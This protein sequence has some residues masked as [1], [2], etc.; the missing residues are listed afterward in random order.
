MPR[1]EGG[2]ASYRA[3][4]A[5]P[6]AR[7]LFAAA[8]LARLC[9]AL[10]G[11]PLLLAMRD[12]TGSYTVAG[13]ATGLAGLGTALLGP[14]RARLVERHH[15]AL[16]ALAWSYALLL[17]ALA[18]ACAG[19]A[20][21]PLTVGLALLA[22][23]CPPPVGPLMR[24]LWGR[25]TVGEAQRQSA[26]SLDTAA[27]STV[28]ALGP[29][30]GGLL[31]AASSA[32]A[33]LA[34]CAVVVVTGFGLLA[35]ALRLVPERTAPGPAASRNPLRAPGFGPLLLLVAA[36]AAALAGTE[37]AALAAWGKVTAGV[38]ATLFSV[39]GVLGG[40]LYGRRS[41]PG[42]LTRRPLVLAAACAA[43][44]ALPAL[45]PVAPAAGVALLL[46][47]ACT[48]VLLI[49]AY[50]LVDRLVPE[51]SR[52]E[53]GA[54]VNTAYNLGAA[55]GAA[56]GG[57]VTDRSGP[58]TAFAGTALVL[59]AAATTAVLP[60][61]LGSVL[62]PPRAGRRRGTHPTC[63]PVGSRGPERPA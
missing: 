6:Y 22:G 34:G 62:K 12:G 48:D 2:S 57:A 42:P 11:L 58:T 10:L 32:P 17:A 13:A 33:V 56:A 39:G 40:L 4:L 44:Y 19:R 37:I 53:A 51:G 54:W 9:Y 61:R 59:T 52:T 63:P 18:A 3:V 25:L 49:T 36:A 24:T 55:L 30:V 26:L 1:P 20:P 27:E 7:R 41:W 50:Q 35:R 29:V 31:A 28:F 43:C 47:G 46:A 16:T 45:L 5:L 14:Y 21:V 38:L 60:G 15:A 23:V 8:M